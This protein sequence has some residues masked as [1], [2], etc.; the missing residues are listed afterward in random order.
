MK[1]SVIVPMYNSEKYIGRCIDTI[2]KQSFNDLELILVNDG[3]KDLSAEVA[4]KYAE[5]DKRITVIDKC[6]GGAS[7]SRNAGLDVA[8]GEYVTFVDSDDW[9]DTDAYEYMFSLEKFAD[10]DIAVF[11]IRSVGDKG[12]DSLQKKADSVQ[13]LEGMDIWDKFYGVKGQTRTFSCCNKI[14]KHDIV[15]NV[16]FIEGMT[17][18][19]IYFN[20]EAFLNSEKVLVTDRSFYNYFTREGSVSY[21]KVRKN[22]YDCMYMWK[23]IGEENRFPEH[24]ADIENMKISDNFSLLLRAAIFGFDSHF[25]EWKEYKKRSLRYFRKNLFNILKRKKLKKGKKIA[26]ILM[27][28]NFGLCGY[29]GRKFLGI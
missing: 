24:K 3:S 19:D 28:I 27:F 22:S 4:K 16:R 1:L 9:L 2:I 26:A 20:Y 21:G 14:Y 8:K 6:N 18:E 15:K 5:A 17:G 23:R 10:A 7:S 13:L 25:K 29:A 12:G 11:G